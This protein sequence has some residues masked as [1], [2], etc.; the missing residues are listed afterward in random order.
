MEGATPRQTIDASPTSTDASTLLWSRIIIFT[1]SK[2]WK[3]KVQKMRFKEESFGCRAGDAHSLGTE[4][5]LLPQL[6]YGLPGGRE[7]AGLAPHHPQHQPRL[8]L[9]PGASVHFRNVLIVLLIQLH[10]SRRLKPA[11]SRLAAVPSSSAP[12]ALPVA[13]RAASAAAGPAGG[14]GSRGAAGPAPGSGVAGGR[15]APPLAGPYLVGLKADGSSVSAV[16][17][18][19]LAVVPE[20]AVGRGTHQLLRPAGRLLA[21]QHLVLEEPVHVVD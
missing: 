14:T 3:K 1:V 21:A 4:R 12:A 18:E 2:N 9:E 16:S 15:A 19:V 7:R 10:F 5:R 17:D 20:Q 13:G 6:S 11:E 8:Q